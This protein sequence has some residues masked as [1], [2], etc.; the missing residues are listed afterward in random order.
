MQ[1]FPKAEAVLKE[2]E[3]RGVGP[4]KVKQYPGTYHGFVIRYAVP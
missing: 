2:M 1:E 4:F 3:G